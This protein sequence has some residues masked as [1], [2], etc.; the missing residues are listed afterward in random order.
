MKHWLPIETVHEHEEASKRFEE[1]YDVKKDSPHYK[2]M[3]LLSILI[4]E[5]EKKH[6][7]LPPVGPI[8]LIV[9]RMEDL[10]LKPS[11]LASAYGDKGTISKVL[12]YKQSL[13]LTMM[14]LFSKLLKIP[15]ELLIKEYKLKNATSS[16]TSKK[17]IRKPRQLRKNST[18]TRSPSTAE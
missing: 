12:N 5:Y 16:A 3:L 15:I 4:S 6:F 9:S 1:I 11:D 7:S 8:E 18:T 13:S 2:E 14:R 10:D 17:N